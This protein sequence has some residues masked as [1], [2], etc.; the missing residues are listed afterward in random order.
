MIAVSA[1]ATTVYILGVFA[2]VWV[3][4]LTLDAVVQVGGAV[5]YAR[6]FYRAHPSATPPDKFLV[7]L[8]LR[9]VR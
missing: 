9:G 7:R 4:M 8:F 6:R 3:T 1:A 5:R 2:L